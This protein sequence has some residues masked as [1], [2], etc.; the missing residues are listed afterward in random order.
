LSAQLRL[1]LDR[2]PAYRREDFVLSPANRSAVA[3]LDRWPAWHGGVLALIGPAGAGKTHLARSWESRTGAIRFDA[4]QPGHGL[5]AAAEASPVLIDDAD[6]LQDDETLFHL[7]NIAART[8]RGLLLTSR[9]LPAAWPTALPDL[10]SR[11][12]ALP[13][14]ELG[15]PDDEIL[16]G[17]MRNLFRD[18]NIRAADDLLA[19][20][21]RRI[22]RSVPEAER[23]VARID[24]A[25]DA[26]G[27]PVSRS[28]ASRVL[29]D[30]PDE[31]D[32]FSDL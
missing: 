31:D 21:V 12:N 17:V 6:Q 9:T 24:E 8:N 14:A 27:R 20:L 4:S 28:L 22:G 18:R 25:A 11:L 15:P 23:M 7:I 32:L 19:Y 10:K 30:G 3:A 26:A 13:V 1:K 29:E 5:D 16:T 2:P